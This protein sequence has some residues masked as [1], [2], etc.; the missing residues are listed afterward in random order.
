MARIAGV[1]IPNNKCIRISLTYIYGIGDSKADKILKQTG[2]DPQIRTKD[3]TEEQVNK[4]REIVEKQHRVEGDL[5]REVLGNIKRLKDIGSYRGIRH[6][7]RLP[8]RGQ[9]T[10]TNSRTVRGNMRKTMGSGRRML[11]KT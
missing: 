4:I 1:T 9:R 6:I 8:A 11:T 3:L 2:V 10:K 7:R 5:R